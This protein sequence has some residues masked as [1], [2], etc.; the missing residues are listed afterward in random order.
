[1][2]FKVRMEQKNKP[3][4]LY[5]YKLKTYIKR[6]PIICIADKVANYHLETKYKSQGEDGLTIRFLKTINKKYLV[7]F[8][9]HHCKFISEYYLLLYQVLGGY[10][11]YRSL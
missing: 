4:V 6:L 3:H 5:I 1:M 11:L 7:L 8:I 2:Q 10:H 9:F